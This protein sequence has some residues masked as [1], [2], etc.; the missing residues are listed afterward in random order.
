[1]NLEYRGYSYVKV[2]EA[3]LEAGEAAEAMKEGRKTKKGNKLS[4]PG[5][6]P[7]TPGSEIQSL[8]LYQLS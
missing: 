2:F 4:Q 3:I 8:T 5:F 1:M 6:E 7:E